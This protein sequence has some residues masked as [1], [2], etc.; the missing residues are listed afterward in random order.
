VVDTTP[1]RR[2][3]HEQFSAP[4]DLSDE[5]ELFPDIIDARGLIPLAD[6]VEETYGIRLSEED[7]RAHAENFRT[8]LTIA[9]LI[10]RNRGQDG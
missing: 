6:F 9:A 8:L 7:L 4:E 1:I 5:R 3:I 10:E 2:F